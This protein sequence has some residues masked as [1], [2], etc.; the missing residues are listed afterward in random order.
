MRRLVEAIKR[1]IAGMRP[2]KEPRTEPDEE[3]R[4]FFGS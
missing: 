3:F 1:W 4:K 2:P